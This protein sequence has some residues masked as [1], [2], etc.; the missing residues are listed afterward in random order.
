L[1]GHEEDDMPHH[2]QV[3]RWLAAAGIAA[4]VAAAAACGATSSRDSK[5]GSGAGTAQYNSNDGKSGTRSR[6][7]SGAGI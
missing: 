1:L 2:I 4:T 7:G 5:P 3:R 6:R